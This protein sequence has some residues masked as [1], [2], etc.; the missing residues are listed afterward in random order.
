MKDV[1]SSRRETLEALSLYLAMGESVS[2]RVDAI[3]KGSATRPLPPVDAQRARFPCCL[4]WTPLPVV[5]WLVP[6]VGHLGICREDG[7]ILDFA[8]SYF[9]MVDSFT[10]G[11]PAKYLQI[12]PRECCFPQ[13]L[14]DHCCQTATWHSDAASSWDDALRRGMGHYQHQ[15]YNIFT[16]NCHS[17]VA[18]CLNI[19]AFKGRCRWN[20]VDLAVMMTL[21]GHWVSKRAMVAAYSPTIIIL[22]L[23]V[24]L[25]GWWFLFWWLAF[26]VALVSWFLLG[27]YALGAVY[28]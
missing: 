5:A 6:F 27:T 18:R 15:A 24:A 11:A 12:D 16:C 9:I 26:G 3:A 22:V 19:V 2:V 21:R 20:V 4:V 13:H 23:G 28:I 14:S 10:F 1:V 8:G 7:V 17:F 25:A